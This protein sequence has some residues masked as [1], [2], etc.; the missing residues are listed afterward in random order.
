MNSFALTWAH[1]QKLYASKGGKNEGCADA[2][3]RDK[4]KFQCPVCNASVWGKPT[5]NVICG[6]DRVNM[7]KAK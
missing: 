5:T 6:K 1:I 7:L 3:D 2:G 4:E